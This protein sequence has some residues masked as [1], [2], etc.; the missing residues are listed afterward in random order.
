MTRP[1][2]MLSGLL[3]LTALCTL[4]AC[5]SSPSDPIVCDASARAG[6]TVTIKDAETMAPLAATAR[7]VVRDGAY[8]DSL[9]LVA[10][11]TRAAAFERP[12]TYSVE[13]RLT[14]YQNFNTSN[15][16]VTAGTCHVNAVVVPALLLKARS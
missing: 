6:I 15:V 14:G 2:S 8:V 5:S 7:G 11:D 13:V 10:S 12:G 3:F 4:G 1:I 16:R 9:I